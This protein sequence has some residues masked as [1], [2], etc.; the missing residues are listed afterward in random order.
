MKNLRNSQIINFKKKNILK[1][2]T[3]DIIINNLIEQ[4][5]NT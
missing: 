5:N 2:L 3:Q 1:V 4:I